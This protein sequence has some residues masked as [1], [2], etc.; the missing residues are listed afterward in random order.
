M[1][2]DDLIRAAGQLKKLP[3]EFYFAAAATDDPGKSGG[4]IAVQPRIGGWGIIQ[5]ER[6]DP[7]ARRGI[8]AQRPEVTPHDPRDAA[9]AAEQFGTDEEG[10]HA[11]RIIFA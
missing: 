6:V 3:E 10:S 5:H 11:P 7:V 4:G 1:P 2:A 9:F 8:L